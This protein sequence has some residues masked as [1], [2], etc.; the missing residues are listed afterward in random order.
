[1]SLSRALT[2]RFGEIVP[3]LRQ[4]EMKE[5]VADSILLTDSGGQL[6]PLKNLST[7]TRDAFLLAAR[8]TLAQRGNTGPGILILDE[9]FH[10]LDAERTEGCLHMLKKIHEDEGWQIILFSKDPALPRSV[11]SI[12]PGCKINR[13]Q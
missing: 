6:R 7:G 8:L 13:I 10:N 5:I 1:M 4:V 3:E 9:P 2:S 11:S 12:F